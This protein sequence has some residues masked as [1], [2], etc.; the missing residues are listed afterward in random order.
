MLGCQLFLRCDHKNNPRRVVDPLALPVGHCPPHLS[1]NSSL[2]AGI[3]SPGVPCAYL[4]AVVNKT[5]GYNRALHTTM[6]LS[7][8][9]RTIQLCPD[10]PCGQVRCSTLV[11]VTRGL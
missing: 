8:G 6:D 10:L 1:D 9:V 4:F 3:L 2:H 11:N 7:L 5:S